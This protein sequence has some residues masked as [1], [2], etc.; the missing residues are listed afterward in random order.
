MTTLTAFTID[1]RVTM[2]RGFRSSAMALS[3]TRADSAAELVFSSCTLAIVDEYGRLMPIA[4]NAE[5]MVFAVYM[6]PQEPGPG[7][8]CSSI[9]RKSV[10]EGKRVSVSVDPGGRRIIKKKNNKKT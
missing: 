6:P 8:A 4:S 2:S 10:V 3:N 7:M 9:D 5:L 1:L